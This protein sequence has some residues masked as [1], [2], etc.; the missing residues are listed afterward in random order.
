MAYDFAFEYQL[1]ERCK[2]DCEYFLWYGNR[3]R[4]YLWGGTVEAHIAKMRELFLILPEKPE[5]LT[6]ED[7]NLYEIAMLNPQ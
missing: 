3:Q 1:L 2:Q 4:K 7:I 6:V 5:W